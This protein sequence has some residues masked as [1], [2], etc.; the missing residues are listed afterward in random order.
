M[1]EKLLEKLQQLPASPGVYLHKSSSG[2]VIYVGKAAVLKNRVRQYFQDSRSRDNKTMALVAEVVDTDWIET[3]SEVDAL[4]LESEL[5][6]RYM[7]RYNILLRD[8]KSQSFVR[9]DMRS[10]WP[11]VTVT[12]NPLDDGAEYIGPFYN[13]LMLRKALRYLRRIFPFLTKARR[14][15]QS[16][17]DEDL[18][19]SPRISDGPEAYK[20]DLRLL[21]Q[22]IK[23]RRTDIARELER[24]M[25]SLAGQQDFEGAAKA[26]N[27][28]M[29]LKE[30]RRRVM[31]GDSEFLDISKDKALSDLATIFGLESEPVRIECFDI[32]HI[33]GTGVVASM[34]V[35]MNGASARSEYRKF[36][37]SKERNDDAANMRE[38]V[39]RRFSPRNLKSWGSPDLVIIDGGKP[40]LM[41]ALE[42]ARGLDAKVPIISVAK[43][44]EELVIH[45]SL[46][47]VSIE[48]MRSLDEAVSLREDGAFLLVDLHPGAVKSSGH[49]LNLRAGDVLSPYDDVVRLIQRIRDESHR[50]AIS[51][52]Q[53]LRKQKQTVSVLDGIPG[54]GPKSRALLLRKFSSAKAVMGASEEQ[55]A[56]VVGP[57]KAKLIVV[58]TG[59]GSDGVQ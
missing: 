31:F 53:V 1:N 41:A 43:R 2:E 46:S 35:F 10:E 45:S 38:V 25:K 3:D 14:P 42:A 50:F 54:V 59:G 11:T 56:D 13:G 27:K 32:S 30:L 7:P 24:S 36:K 15:G 21:M 9:I 22:Y 12:R 37:L 52:H 8:D 6:K 44:H 47:N 5:V 26:R 40:Q 23:G 4:F 51:Y 57:A 39:L 17:L 28:L 58:A 48:S 20:S 49:S 19:I 18:G 34:A 29:A 33:S 55:L 16:Q